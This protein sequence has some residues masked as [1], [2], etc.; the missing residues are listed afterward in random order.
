[1]CSTF[2]ANSINIYT[3]VIYLQK[4]LILYYPESLDP[5]KLACIFLTIQQF[6]QTIPDL[7]APATL[8]ARLPFSVQTLEVKP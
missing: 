2:S 6:T 1:M 3:L 4:S 7:I 8:L 5:P